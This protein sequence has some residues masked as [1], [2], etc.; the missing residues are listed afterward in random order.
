MKRIVVLYML[1]FTVPAWSGV[2]QYRQSI[3]K[4][5]VLWNLPVEIIQ[6]V[7]YVE[8]RFNTEARSP[9]GAIGLM[10]VVPDSGGREIWRLLFNEDRSPSRKLLRDPHSNIMIGT[11]YLAHLYHRYF[12]TIENNDIRIM[13]A[14][15]GYN[16]GPGRVKALLKRYGRPNSTT[17]MY[18]L[19]I[20]Y[21]PHETA[22]Y[23]IFVLSKAVGYSKARLPG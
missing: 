7:I 18:R 19:L 11:A 8:S 5:A 4:N 12:C 10:Q 13:V 16:W 9:K 17:E 23:V 1:L 22:D 2:D 6:S 20:R 3:E 15:A 14:L 21:A